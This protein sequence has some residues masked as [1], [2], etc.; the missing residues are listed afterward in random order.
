[1]LNAFNAPVITRRRRRKTHLWQFGRLKRAVLPKLAPELMLGNV[2]VGR[3]LLRQR[4]HG[5]HGENM[6]TLG[7]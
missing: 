5:K 7:M 6:R 3:L 1:L 2:C 4:N